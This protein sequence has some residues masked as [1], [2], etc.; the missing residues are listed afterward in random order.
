MMNFPLAIERFQKEPEFEKISDKEFLQLFIN[1][2]NAT[3]EIG[4]R[5]AYS[6]FCLT[7]EMVK[8]WQ[9]R[10]YG[11]EMDREADKIF[12]DVFTEYSND[13]YQ[14]G[15]RA[16]GRVF[17]IP[18][19]AIKIFPCFETHSPKAEKMEQKERYFIETGLLQSQI[20]LDSWGNLIDG[21]TSYLLA[22]KYGLQSVP[23]RY[24]KRQIVKASYKPGKKA[25]S[26]ELPKILINHVS[27]GDN[28]LVHTQK[29]VR[30]VTV[31]AVEEYVG[32]EPEPLR[33]VI[34]VK[35]TSRV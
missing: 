4:K 21:Y 20:I 10:D 6:G 15:V 23:V 32:N 34:R 27:V 9:K 2:I 19:D 30:V 29:G 8:A 1:A 18:T 33:M 31:A 11:I 28:V 3:Y 13:A 14:Q 35:Q 25:Y 12:L 5:K 26:W 7:V 24:G 17:D 22:I 16:S